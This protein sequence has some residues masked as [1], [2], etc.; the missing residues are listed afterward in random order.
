MNS[1]SIECR[2]NG[3]SERLRESHTA[4]NRPNG[5]NH[6]TGKLP[7]RR[8]PCTIFT[9]VELLVVIAIIAIL[10]GMLLPAL[11]NAREKGRLISCAANFKQI[12][13][14]VNTYSGENDE[15]LTPYQTGGGTYWITL[16]K[17]FLSIGYYDNAKISTWSPSTRREKAGVFVC[18][19]TRYS[20]DAANPD[21]LYGYCQLNSRT[22]G[23]AANTDICITSCSPAYYASG[24]SDGTYAG[25]TLK[26]GKIPASKYAWLYESRGNAAFY[27]HSHNTSGLYS[28]AGE[29]VRGAS[30]HNSGMNVMYIDG[31]VAFTKHSPEEEFVSSAIN[32]KYK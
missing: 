2:M 19:S 12:G 10:A 17:P 26:T 25:G 24:T 30:R 11:N 16:L 27:Y 20:N 22:P 7:G 4:E 15:Y 9:L 18:P 29:D 13:L 3:V 31:H 8:P 23:G 32:A 28:T 14:A 5:V 6:G 1:K 21:K